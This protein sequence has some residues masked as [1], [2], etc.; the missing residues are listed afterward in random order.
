LLSSQPSFHPF[1][2]LS[3]RF[4][5]DLY[6]PHARLSPAAF[7]ALAYPAPI[8]DHTKARDRAL[9]R[10][11]HVGE[12]E[13]GANDDPTAASTTGV[14]VE[15]KVDTKGGLEK[16]GFGKV[17]PEK[18]KNTGA[19]GKGKTVKEK[20]GKA[21]KTGE[22]GVV[23]INREE[24]QSG[25]E[26]IVIDEARSTPAKGKASSSRKSGGGTGKTKANAK[27]TLEAFGFKEKN[28]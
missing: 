9:F 4:F 22:E 17:T 27:G 12:K 23:D 18:G 14:E 15:G 7:K 13:P 8:V 10:F 19:S 28:E 3:V 11:K 2:F 21:G 6:E 26:E 16:F 25:E 1:C 20:E 24:E 5:T